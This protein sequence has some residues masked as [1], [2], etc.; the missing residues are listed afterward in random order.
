MVSFGDNLRVA[1]RQRGI[2]QSNLG[3]SIQ[4][5]QA[6]ISQFERGERIPSKEKLKDIESV[7]N[8]RLEDLMGDDEISLLKDE[9]IKILDNLTIDSLRELLNK[10]GDFLRI[11]HGVVD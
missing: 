1:R 11:E 6:S 10:A 5:T 2:S 8:V 4:L 9:L 7:L 3:K